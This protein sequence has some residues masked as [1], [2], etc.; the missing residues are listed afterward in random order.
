MTGI[1]VTHFPITTSNPE[2]QMWFDQ[3][4]TL[5]HSFWY[6]EAERA[7]R[8]AAKLDP[9]A[10]MPYWGLVRS[11]GGGARARAFMKEAS[12]RKAKASERERAYIEAWELQS[13]RGR[14]GR[15]RPPLHQSAR[16]DR[17]EIPGRHR[18][19]GAARPR[20]DWDEPRRHRA[21]DAAGARQGSEPS[22]RAPLP[23][24]QLG[25]RGWRAALD[26][27]RVYGDIVAGHRSRAAHARAHLCRRRHVPRVG[28]LARFRDARRDRLHGPADGVSVQHLELRAQSQLP[29]L[30]AG[31]A[32]ACRRKRFAARAS[33]SPCRSTP[34][35]T[36][37]PT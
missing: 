27:C 36:S 31:A 25:R 12:K 5:L 21:A 15:R 4:H 11:V 37:R 2:V 35:S 6:Y 23:H 1:G 20:D 22:G 8:W 30:R 3:G 9:D 19:Q 16:E 24:S 28:D 13:R 33:C 7:F 34:S 14:T 10:P 29:E 26:S 18:S 17:H 32:R